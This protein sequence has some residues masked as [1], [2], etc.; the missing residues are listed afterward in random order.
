MDRVGREEAGQFLTEG[1]RGIDWNNGQGACEVGIIAVDDEGSRTGCSGV[2]GALIGNISINDA[3]ACE[4]G[5]FSD[6]EPVDGGQRAVDNEHARVDG[7]GSAEAE[8]AVDNEHAA[9]DAGVVI[10]EKIAIGD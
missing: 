10:D 2:H 4:H 6:G 1:E 5:I 3:C 7:S 8:V 9:I